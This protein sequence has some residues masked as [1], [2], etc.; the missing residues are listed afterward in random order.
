[1]NALQRISIMYYFTNWSLEAFAKSLETR[2][3]KNLAI[4]GPA[5][6]GGLC[7]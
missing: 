6:T 7:N 3:L 1:M 2:V 4:L 5:V